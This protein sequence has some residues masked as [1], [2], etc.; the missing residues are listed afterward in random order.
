MKVEET[1]ERVNTL[2]TRFT[3]RG[4]EKLKRDHPPLLETYHLRVE[5]VRLF[6]WEVVAY[7]NLPAKEERA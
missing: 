5:K 7:Q 2:G 6:K 3:R 4:A 1:D